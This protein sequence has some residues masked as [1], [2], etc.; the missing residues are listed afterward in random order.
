[1]EATTTAP[2]ARPPLPLWLGLLLAAAC[3]LVIAIPASYGMLSPYSLAIFFAAGMW[4]ALTFLTRLPGALVIVIPAALATPMFF[5]TYVWEL[6]LYLLFALVILHGWRRRADWLFRFSEVE[7]ALA[8]FTLFAL[9]S[10]F[11]SSDARIYTIQ[12]RRLCL[13][14]IS[15]WCAARM[16]HVA[17]RRWFE[18]GLLCAALSVGLAGLGRRLSSGF[19]A[20]EAIMRRPEVTNLGWGTANFLATLLLLIAPVAFAMASESRGPRRVFAWFTFGVTAVMQVV[21]ASRAGMTLFVLGTLVQI[22]V[23]GRRVR[24]GAAGIL[25]LFAGLL[26]SPMGGDFFSRFTSLRDLGSMAIRVWYWRE[27]WARLLEHLPFGLGLGQGYVQA[28]RL[29]EVDPH[30]YWL[31][32]GGDLGVLG[33]ALWI[34][35]LVA[36]WRGIDRLGANP[37]RRAM[38]IALRISFVLAQLHTL[39]EPTFQGTQYAF[40]W[41][42]LFGGLLAYGLYV[43]PAGEPAASSRL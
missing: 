40:E 6:L 28:D 18:I 25:A 20:E 3:A 21:I 22:L 4:L 16:V 13:G 23:T 36:V 27:G 2:Q 19:S 41:F 33:L 30:N 35:V 31:V 14:F 42:W 37:E 26:A 38:V 12:V 29:R 9:F 43:T 7:V 32:V 15:L 24:W 5:Y 10:G 39:V 17:N 34:A 11:W 8:A 1:M